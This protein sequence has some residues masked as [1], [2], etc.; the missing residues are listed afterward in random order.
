MHL[1]QFKR[2]LNLLLYLALL[3]I[4]HRNKKQLRMTGRL[5]DG[6]RCISDVNCQS[7][8]CDY[9]KGLVCGPPKEVSNYY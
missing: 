6:K 4:V 9:V 5:V 3:K 1:F 7:G 2:L 8:C